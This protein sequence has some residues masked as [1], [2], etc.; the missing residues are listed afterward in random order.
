VIRAFLFDFD[1]LLLDTESASHT[2]WQEVFAEFG[3]EFPSSDW[4]ATIGSLKTFDSIGH[5]EGL[6]VELDRETVVARRRARRDELLAERE[7]RDGVGDYLDEA[8]RRNLQT[9]I[10]TSADRDWVVGHLARFHRAEGWDA[11]V[12]ADGDSSRAKP[13]PTLYLEAL[14]LLGV[15]NDE[16]IAFEDSPNGVQAATTAGIFC[17][18]VPNSLTRGLDLSSADLVVG[19]LADLRPAELVRQVE[20]AA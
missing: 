17:V 2:A 13:A 7:L 16:A 12:S 14:D 11:I 10:V 5:L 15:A 4:M 19:S 18:A 8:A 6:G 3:H 20:R 1:G 9:A